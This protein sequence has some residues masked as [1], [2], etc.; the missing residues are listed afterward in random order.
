M[1]GQTAL[2]TSI[3]LGYRAT[4]RSRKRTPVMYKGQTQTVHLSIHW[5]KKRLIKRMVFSNDYPQ[6]SSDFSPQIFFCG[7]RMHQPNLR[8]TIIELRNNVKQEVKAIKLDVFKYLNNNFCVMLKKCKNLIRDY[9]E[10]LL[11]REVW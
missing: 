11:W 3:Q 2:A 9:M 1:V 4:H 10:Y 8:T 5:I 6:H 7:D